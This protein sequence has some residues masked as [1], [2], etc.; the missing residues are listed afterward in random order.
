M[1]KIAISHCA[2]WEIFKNHFQHSRKGPMS[3]QTKFHPFLTKGKK[4]TGIW[5]KLKFPT[6]HSEKLSKI[7]FNT[8]QKVQGVLSTNFIHFHQKVKKLQT[9]EKNWKFPLCTVGNYQKILSTLNRRSKGT[10]SHCATGHI[11][12]TKHNKSII[13]YCA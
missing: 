4:V 9:F 12:C 2:Q 5:K 8:Q 7:T 11:V 3:S 1:K 6:V 13:S 10:I